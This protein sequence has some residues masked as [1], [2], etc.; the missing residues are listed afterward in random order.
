MMRRKDREITANQE[1]DGIIEKCECLRLALNDELAPYV[2]PL[3]FG[4]VHNDNG[5][6][7]YFHGAN[8]GKKKDL[9]EKAEFA[10]F[11]LDR[12]IAIVKGQ[13]AS[14]YTCRYE[15]VIGMGRVSFIED[16]NEKSQ[17]LDVIM[18]MYSDQSGWEYPEAMLKNTLVF[19][20]EVTQITAKANRG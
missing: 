13:A 17:A 9:L 18:A 20:L 11:E 10:G 1:I 7:F 4:F 19:K 6:T 16:L 14:D 12:V 15:S 5:R 2:V 8:A 3:N